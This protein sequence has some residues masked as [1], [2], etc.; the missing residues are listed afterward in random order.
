MLVEVGGQQVRNA[1]RQLATQYEPPFASSAP[2]FQNLKDLPET[3]L[4]L[5]ETVEMTAAGR[6]A[7]STLNV[8]NGDAYARLARMRVE[9]DQPEGD[10]PYVMFSDNFIDFLPNE[11]A[12]IGLD[13]LLPKENTGNMSGTLV[14]EGPNIETQRIPI[15]L[16]GSQ[17]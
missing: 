15:N 2:L 1:Y 7:T 16:V 6:R 10:T 9:W 12:S 14:V 8:T 13:F 5:P 17:K 3:T 4:R 11:S